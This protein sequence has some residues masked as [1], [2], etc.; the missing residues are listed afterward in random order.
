T[1]ACCRTAKAAA[2]S[3]KTIRRCR[4]T[5]RSRSPRLYR[6]RDGTSARIRDLA[7]ADHGTAVRVGRLEPGD[8]HPG[9][10]RA[11]VPDEPVVA[12]R[13]DAAPHGAAPHVDQ[14]DARAPALPVRSTRRAKDDAPA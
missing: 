12:G 13:E 1:K 4:A 14:R 8:V 11:A 6:I 5:A 10:R 9:R 3:R 7:L 2:R